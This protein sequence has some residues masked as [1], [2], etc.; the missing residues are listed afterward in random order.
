MEQARRKGKGERERW[1]GVELK[2]EF[3]GESAERERDRNRLNRRSAN[4]GG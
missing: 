2:C 3:N 4:E 1:E